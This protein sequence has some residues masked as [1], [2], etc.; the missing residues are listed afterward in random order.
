MGTIR[1][2]TGVG[3]GASLCHRLAKYES[4][5]TLDEQL[6]LLSLT[7]DVALQDDKPVVHAMLLSAR[8]MTPLMVDIY[9]RPASVRHARSR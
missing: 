5:V 2:P 4:S 1:H 3:V 7:G 8:K 6:E 9:L